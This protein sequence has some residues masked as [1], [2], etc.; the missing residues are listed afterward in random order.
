LIVDFLELKGDEEMRKAILVASVVLAMVVP[1]SVLAG[2]PITEKITGGGH[3]LSDVAGTLGNESYL[4]MVGMERDGSWY[5][6]GSYRDKTLSLEAHLTV[7]S[8]FRHGT[9]ENYVCAEGWAEVYVNDVFQTDSRFRVC[10][11][12]EDW[13]G[14]ADRIG[15]ILY[16]YGGYYSH[17]GTANRDYQGRLKIH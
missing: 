10:I 17:M 3:F 7:D 5:G 13:D 2:T 14:L 16:D 12:D 6:S 1:A 8:G 9:A 15:V 11:T 4:S